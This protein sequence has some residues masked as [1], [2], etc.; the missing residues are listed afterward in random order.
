M[1]SIHAVA[2]MSSCK[3]ELFSPF[4]LQG[5]RYKHEE[6]RPVMMPLNPCLLLHTY[7][8]KKEERQIIPKPC[9]YCRIWKM[10]LTYGVIDRNIE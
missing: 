5:S 4:W 7:L 1:P 9:A 6:S 10:I 8:H 3:V 2:K